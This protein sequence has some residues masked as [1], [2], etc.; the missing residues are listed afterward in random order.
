[1]SNR[2]GQGHNQ[3]PPLED[4]RPPWGDGDAYVYFCW[5]EAH[6]KAWK[7]IPWDTALR[8]LGRAEQ[9]GLTYQEYTLEILERGRYLQ[10]TDLERIEAIKRKRLL[11]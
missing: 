10:A 7:R 5:K 2:I 3:G 6:H 4:T 8:R 11:R 9:L 1:M